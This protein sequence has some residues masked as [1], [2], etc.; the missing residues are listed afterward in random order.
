MG[1]EC[2]GRGKKIISLALGS[3]K[4]QWCLDNGFRPIIKFGYPGSLNNAGFC[5]S[6]TG[7]EKKINQLLK[8]ILLMKQSTFDK[9]IYKI[10][11]KIMF[12]DPNNTKFKRLLISKEFQNND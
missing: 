12:F 8:D 3:L 2:L 6:N 10:K 7:S 5:W 4:R 11:S 1:Y 9:K